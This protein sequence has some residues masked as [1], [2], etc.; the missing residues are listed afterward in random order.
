MAV[1]CIVGDDASLSLV[2]LPVA[3]QVGSSGRFGLL[4]LQLCLGVV[5]S[6]VPQ[7]EFVYGSRHTLS[8]TQC[9][10]TFVCRYSLVYKQWS[11]VGGFRYC[12]IDYSSL[13]FRFIAYGEVAPQV[14]RH[15]FLR[16]VSLV[17]Y[18]YLEVPVIVR[19]EY[20]LFLS[21]SV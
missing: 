3:H 2:H 19:C 18:C 12:G 6:H 5:V 9:A 11:S 16:G 21:V 10:Y 1:A 17:S 8:Y 15:E 14:L 20:E 7:R 4:S 13:I